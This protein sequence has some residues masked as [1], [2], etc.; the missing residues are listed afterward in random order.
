LFS[1]ST[2]AQPLC[3]ASSATR[4]SWEVTPSAASQTTM[5]TSARSAARRLRSVV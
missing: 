2:V 5:A 4:R 3:M 1:A